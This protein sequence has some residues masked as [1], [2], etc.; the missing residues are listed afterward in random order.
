MSPCHKCARPS[1]RTLGTQDWCHDCAEA[2][3][4]PLRAKHTPAHFGGRGQPQTA[5]PA[6]LLQCD[7]CGATWHGAPHEP[8][9]YCAI[10]HAIAI[11]YQ[12]EIVLTAPDDTTDDNAMNAWADRLVIAVEAGIVTQTEADRTW[13]RATNARP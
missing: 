12:T 7:Q 11:R 4:A 6:G 2:L 5:E 8:C 1:T 10:E 13:K 3:L 9:N